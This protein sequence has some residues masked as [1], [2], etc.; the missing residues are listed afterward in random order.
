[1]SMSDREARHRQLR[2]DRK[3]VLAR[4]EQERAQR[5][6]EAR[7]AAEQQAAAEVARTPRVRAR[8]PLEIATAFADR[9]ARIETEKRAAR[10]VHERK[11]TSWV[12]R[13]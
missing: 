13:A 11:F 8:D 4:E 7:V 6:V 12:G 10:A 1:M 3:A 2:A 5:A 9:A